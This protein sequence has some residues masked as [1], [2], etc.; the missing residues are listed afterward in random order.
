MEDV[1]KTIE[2]LEKL[3]PITNE[4]DL[5]QIGSLICMLMEEWCK[6]NNENIVEFVNNISDIVGEVQEACGK[7]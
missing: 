4:F 7:Y 1:M 2:L 6:A 3:K 5:P